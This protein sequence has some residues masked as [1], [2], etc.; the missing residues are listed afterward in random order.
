MS[1]DL[2][3]RVAVLEAEVARPR[4]LSETMAGEATFAG[5]IAPVCMTA[6]ITAGALSPATAREALDRFLLLLEEQVGA[7]RMPPAMLDHARGRAASL[8]ARLP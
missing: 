2:T 5:Q 1:H 4:Q 8:L 7:G 6:L 3:A